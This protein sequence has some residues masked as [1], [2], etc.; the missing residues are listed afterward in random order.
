MKIQASFKGR[1]SLF[2]P[3][4]GVTAW[5]MLSP[6]SLQPERLRMGGLVEDGGNGNRIRA[7]AQQGLSLFLVAIGSVVARRGIAMAWA[8]TVSL[9]LLHMRW[10]KERIKL[11]LGIGSIHSCMHINPPR[12][13]T[14]FFLWKKRVQTTLFS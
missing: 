8:E 13:Q 7:G 4:V 5:G 6:L 3:V 14:R 12:V 9:D 1:V 10:E 11:A 2:L